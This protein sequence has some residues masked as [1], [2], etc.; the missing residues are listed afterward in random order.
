MNE[1]WKDLKGYEG[2]YKM[3]VDGE[4]I[5]IKRIKKKPL[6]PALNNGYPRIVLSRENKR[7]AYQISQLYVDN[8]YPDMKNEEVVNMIKKTIN[9]IVAS[10]MQNNN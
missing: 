10:R 5:N 2:I 4:I 3:N 1:R 8:F 6:K 7:K 9:E